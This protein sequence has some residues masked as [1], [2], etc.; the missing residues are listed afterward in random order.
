MGG[1]SNPGLACLA[2]H[3]KIEVKEEVN[4]L[5]ALSAII[6]QEIEMAN[7][8]KVFADG[9]E[10]ELFYAVEQTDCCTRQMKQCAPD[11]APW[12]LHVLYTEG[13]ANMNA[14]HL[15][16]GSTCTCCCFNRPVVE[17][18]D[19]TTGQKMGSLKDP[20]ACCDL[21]F[22]VRDPNDEDALKISGG[23]CQW[24]LC[25][26]LPCGPCAE[27]NFPV[28]D[29]K[30]GAEVGHVQKKVPSCCKFI[31]APDVDNYKIDFGGVQSPQYKALLLA[32]AIFLDFRYFNENPNDDQGGVMGQMQMG[33]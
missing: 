19:A 32:F 30:S 7:K 26:P 24:G 11:C 13:G 28:T 27:V 12:N 4:F 15:E 33:D 16:R 5:E 2:Q 22:T 31:F 10:Y 21:T 9:G 8:Y 23:C 1:G 3:A 14:F 18:L 25:C 29:A 20:F 17:V 6:G